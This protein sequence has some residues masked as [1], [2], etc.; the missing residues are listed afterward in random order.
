MM[1]YEQI[2]KFGR[3]WEFLDGDGKR[4]Q[5][6]AI[7]KGIVATQERVKL[8]LYLEDSEQLEKFGIMSDL[9]THASVPNYVDPDSTPGS[10][11]AVLGQ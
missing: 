9:E 3:D 2:S 1:S 4:T 10:E 5:I 8:K 7:L 11:R 6:Q